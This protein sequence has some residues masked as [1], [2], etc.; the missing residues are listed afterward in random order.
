MRISAV[1]LWLVPHKS[2]PFHSESK[3]IFTSVGV[4]SGFSRESSLG[5][6]SGTP[7]VI[8]A[9]G[10]GSFE[11]APKDGERVKEKRKRKRMREGKKE[12][13]KKELGLN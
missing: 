4:G 6:D 9:A 11:T 2:S 10:E 13:K 12:R 5:E 7:L 8:M 3:M 1:N